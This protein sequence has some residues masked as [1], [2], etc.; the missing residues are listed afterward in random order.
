MINYT[1]GQVNMVWHPYMPM[2]DY[3]KEPTIIVKGEGIY[4]EDIS[5]KKYIDASSSL[6]NVCLG[7]GNREIIDMIIEQLNMLQYFPLFGYSN[8]P[9]LKLA[10]KISEITNG[11]Y[12]HFLFTNSGSEAIDTA[13]KIA[14]QYFRNKGKNN[15]IKII[16]LNRGFHGVTF[17]A[18]S[19]GGIKL[20]REKFEPL[21]DGFIKIEP[22][23]CFRCVYN[24]TYP[25][26]KLACANKLEE[27]IIEED[28]ETVAAFLAE[29]VLGA[30]G[31]I[32]PPHEYFKIIKEICNKYDVKFITDEVT[33][34]FG[35]IGNVLGL[36]NWNITSDIFASAKGISSGYL[37]L[38]VVGVTEEIYEAFLGGLDKKLNHGFTTTGHPV[39]CIAALTTLNILQREG[40]FEQ[41]KEKGEYFSYIL[42]ELKEISIVKDIR[43]KGLMWGI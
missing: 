16:S 10:A 4:V 30:G 11:R 28:P 41:V 21:M 14:R 7:H 17:G 43:G 19:A 25:S 38:G 20:E 39:C 15:K 34:G 42:E 24:K 33:T 12:K 9:S 27:V 37:P 31:I 36:D 1:E 8:E 29:P 40:M 35:R 3:S 23:Y 6:W 18:M 2:G 13:I 5:G 26:C 22:P 32:V